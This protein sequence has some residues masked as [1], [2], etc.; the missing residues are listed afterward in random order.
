MNS[1]DVIRKAI[2]RESSSWKVPKFNIDGKQ[3]F[4]TKCEDEQNRVEVGLWEGKM[5]PVATFHHP[6]SPDQVMSAIEMH[7]VQSS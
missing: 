1:I 4:F 3:Y 6:L 5:N 2:R 7:R